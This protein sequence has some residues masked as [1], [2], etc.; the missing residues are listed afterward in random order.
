MSD[1]AV[2]HPAYCDGHSTSEDVRERRPAFAVLPV[3]AFEQHGAHLPLATDSMT[4]AWVAREVAARLGGLLLPTIP[5]GT[6][7]E[8][9]GMPGTISLGWATLAALVVDI[10]LECFDQGIG[11]VF[12]MSGH[13][14]NFVLNPCLRELNSR[15]E[16]AGRA[17]LVP[18]AVFFGPDMSDD[19][20]HAGAWETSLVLALEP[21]SVRLDRA[22]DFVPDGYE[23][24]E[25]TNLPLRDLA[26]SG[27]WGRPSL[28]RPDEGGRQLAAMVDRV[29]AYVASWLRVQDPDRRGST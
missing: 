4:V 5:Y 15:R 8:H 24:A 13:G 29:S 26:P 6:S 25:L 1:H 9:R 14:G 27:V 18:E 20:L 2:P 10:V 17:V 19:D 23:R 28:A 12:V 22:R 3:G 11:T 21:T 7:F 16:H